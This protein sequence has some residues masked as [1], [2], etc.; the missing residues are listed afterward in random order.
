MSSYQCKGI[1]KAGLICSQRYS[2]NGFCSMQ[3]QIRKTSTIINSAKDPTFLNS[4]SAPAVLATSEFL[5]N[6]ST[7]FPP[8]HPSTKVGADLDLGSHINTAGLTSALRKEL[9]DVSRTLTLFPKQMNT[10]LL[11]IVV[12]RREGA[13]SDSQG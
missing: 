3:G 10:C 4:P 5:A 13:G 8:H 9:A 12:R 11:C 1:T 2:S 7:G 6:P